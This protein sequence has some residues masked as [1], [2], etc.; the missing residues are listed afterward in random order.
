MSHSVQ[1]TLIADQHVQIL[2]KEINVHDL[3]TI[4]LNSDGTIAS[5]QAQEFCVRCEAPI[6]PDKALYPIP[7]DDGLCCVPCYN[8]WVDESIKAAKD[9]VQDSPL[10]KGGNEPVKIFDD[11]CYEVFWLGEPPKPGEFPSLVAGSSDWD[12]HEL[13]KGI[14]FWE[15]RIMEWQGFRFLAFI[16]EGASLCVGICKAD[17]VVADREPQEAQSSPR[18]Y[19]ICTTCKIHHYDNCG[20]CFRFGGAYAKLIPV[21][22]ERHFVPITAGAAHSSGATPDNWTACPECG[23]GSDGVPE[24]TRDEGCPKCNLLAE[25]YEQLPQTPRNYWV[26]TELFVHLHGSDVCN[27]QEALKVVLIVFAVLAQEGEITL[28]HYTAIKKRL[29]QYYGE[30]AVAILDDLEKR[31]CEEKGK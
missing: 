20:T 18:D 19:R 21:D 16:D 26:M 25:L 12:I 5:F 22:S 10:V 6:P 27:Y 24:S 23:S 14:T 9:R 28:S 13:G 11:G 2:G 4:T 15:A 31:L 8:K 7:G 1:V 3:K 29:E 17:S 30:S